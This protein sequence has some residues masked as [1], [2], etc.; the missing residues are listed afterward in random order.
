MKALRYLERYFERILLTIALLVMA[1]VLFAQV[2]MRYFLRSPF[3]WSEELARYVLVWA[4]IIGVSL[5]VRERKH[6]SVD[7]LPLIFGE[8]SYRIFAVIAHIG[9]LAFSFIMISASIPLIERLQAI[10]QTSPAL[11]IPMWMV[12]AAIPVGF[13]LT[14]LRTIQ[15]LVMDFVSPRIELNEQGDI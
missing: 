10:G 6:I 7:F 11:G 1:T 14:L 2:I 3:V 9:V 12:Y 4:A 13:S 15:A 8:R 5:A